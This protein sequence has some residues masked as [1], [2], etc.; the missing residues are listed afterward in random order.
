MMFCS[1]VTVG[2]DLVG[3]LACMSYYVWSEILSLELFAE[4]ALLDCCT[5]PHPI[6]GVIL[7]ISALQVV[8]SG[9]HQLLI[10]DS[11]SKLAFSVAQCRHSRTSAF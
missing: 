4:A 8:A 11:D 3:K 10:R 1:V 6:L 2:V 7:C 9:V 5:H